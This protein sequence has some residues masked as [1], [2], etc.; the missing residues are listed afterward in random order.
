MTELEGCSCERNERAL[1]V[2][3]HT[4]DSCYQQVLSQLANGANGV[5][6]LLQHKRFEKKRS[7]K[8][9]KNE[10]LNPLHRTLKNDWCSGGVLRRNSGLL[11][12]EIVSGSACGNGQRVVGRRRI[13]YSIS[14]ENLG[15][16]HVTVSY[17][18]I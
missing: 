3:K 18:R 4:S 8:G 16:S 6:V 7:T 1:V 10:G 13:P 11:K 2:N 14:A 5:A 15:I 9:F 12:H 17:R